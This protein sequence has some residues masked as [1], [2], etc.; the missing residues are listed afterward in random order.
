MPR[1]AIS[2]STITFGLVSIPVEL[3]PVTSPKS[4]HFNLVHAK[5]NSRIREQIY[6]IAEDQPVDRSELVHGFQVKKGQYV[7]FTNEEL[8]ALESGAG[9]EIEIL[10][11]IPIA[12]VDPVYFAAAYLLGCMSESAKAYHLLTAAMIK[13]QRAALAK[14]VMRGKEH[15]VLLRPYHDLLMLHTMHYSDEIRPVEEIAHGAQASVGASELKLA[16]RLIDDLSRNEF[17]ADQFQDTY[18]QKIL[19]I[20]QQKAAGKEITAPAAPG[21]GKV[22][23]LMAA[24]KESLKTRGKKA[25]AKADED[26]VAHDVAPRRGKKVRRGTKSSRHASSRRARS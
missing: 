3:F 22:I 20:A 5:D 26:A 2:R 9:R 25:T 7:T 4:I 1:R 15:L 13:S 8:K 10:Q 16:Q 24:L 6:C 17:K 11:F 12:T 21:R 19:Q 18:R 23:D 14:F